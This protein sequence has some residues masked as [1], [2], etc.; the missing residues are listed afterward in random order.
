MSLLEYNYNNYKK[1]ISKYTDSN[2][3][4]KLEDL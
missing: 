1:K 3:V 4:T 2:K